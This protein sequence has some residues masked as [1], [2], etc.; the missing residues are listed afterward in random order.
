MPGV[1]GC[2]DY[3]SERPFYESRNQGSGLWGLTKGTDS[4]S[5]TFPIKLTDWGVES[6]GKAGA[7]KT[8]VI[9][10]GDLLCTTPSSCFVLGSLFFESAWR[11]R[12]AALRR[13]GKGLVR[14]T[15]QKLMV[16]MRFLRC[17]SLSSFFPLFLWLLIIKRWLFTM[18]LLN[19][20][21]SIQNV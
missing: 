18:F 2:K 8:W 7:L 21:S 19:G 6:C 1:E 17:V 11:K 10:C 15:G 20:F 9:R 3:T 4:Q 12:M 16:G 5:I 14:Q 13:C